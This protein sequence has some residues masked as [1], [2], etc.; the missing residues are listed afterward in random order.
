MPLA[1]GWAVSCALVHLPA[2]AYMCA[3]A[4]A[5]IGIGLRHAC[6][7]L[8]DPDR[9]APSGLWPTNFTVTISPVISSLL[10]ANSP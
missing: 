7:A 6:P 3:I 8:L 9:D 5:N 4:G 1:T 10:K 2:F